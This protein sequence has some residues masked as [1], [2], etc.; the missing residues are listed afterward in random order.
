MITNLDPCGS[1]GMTKH[2][3]DSMV[4]ALSLSLNP[5]T[6]S[7]RRPPTAQDEDEDDDEENG[8]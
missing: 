5:S 8:T 3:L 7:K 2:S 1:S 6:T 4:N